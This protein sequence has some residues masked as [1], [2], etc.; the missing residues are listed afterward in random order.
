MLDTPKIVQVSD[1]RIAAIHLTVP[2]AEIRKVMGPGIAELRAVLAAQGVVPTG[3]WFTYH[4]RMDPGIFD[5]QIGLPVSEPV[6]A[7]GR[8]KPARLPAATLARTV[9]HGG[10]EGLAAAW[11][12]FDAW[13][14]ASGHVPAPD[15]WEV[16]SLGPES[17]PDPARWCTELNQPLRR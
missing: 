1:Q 17:S 7:S 14:K 15:L 13:I 11:G 5:F 9:Y 6:T 4:L 3:P 10:Y 8:V 12:E 16:Y 2:R